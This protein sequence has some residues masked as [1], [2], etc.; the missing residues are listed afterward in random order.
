MATAGRDG[1][2]FVLAATVPEMAE[3]GKYSEFAIPRL[4]E[5]QTQLGPIRSLAKVPWRREI[6]GVSGTSMS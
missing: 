6:C 1:A 4:M 3:K 5:Y 2:M